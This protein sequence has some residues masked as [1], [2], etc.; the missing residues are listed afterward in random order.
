MSNLQKTD[1][2]HT[3]DI[4][5]K[6]QCTLEYVIPKDEE[7]EE[8]DHHKRIRTF[9]EEHVETEDDRES[10]TEEIRQTVKCVDQRKAPG[11]EQLWYI[12]TD[13]SKCEQRVGSGVA[14]FTG[15]VLTE[16]L[17]F[18]LDNRCSKNQAEQLAI[19]KA[20]EFIETQ[21]VNNNEH[22]K[23]VLYIWTAR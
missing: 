22:R 1:G 13:G 5:E 2:S 18:K 15:K 19:L 8:A 14:V 23:S 17:K 20:L 16:Q 4:R 11:E 7:A 3:E 12:F 6:I 9:F 10:T 21:Q